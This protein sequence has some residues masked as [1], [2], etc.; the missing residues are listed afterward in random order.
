MEVIIDPE[1]KCEF[2]PYLCAYCKISGVCMDYDEGY[3][4]LMEKID[5]Q[6]K[7]TENKEE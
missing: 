7:E 6:I 3:V 4:N 2:R 1:G 5:K